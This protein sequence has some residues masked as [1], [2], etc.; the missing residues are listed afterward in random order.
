VAAGWAVMASLVCLPHCQASHLVHSA[1]G[2]QIQVTQRKAKILNKNQ[3]VKVCC[4]WFGS[5]FFCL[6]LLPLLQ[7][8]P[9]RLQ[10][11]SVPFRQRGNLIAVF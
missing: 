8:R 7:R 9:T 10:L 3:S 11:N 1:L 4:L 2:F 6:L 5:V